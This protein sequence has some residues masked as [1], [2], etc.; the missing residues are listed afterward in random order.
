MLSKYWR[1]TEVLGQGQRWVYMQGDF[2]VKYPDGAY[3]FHGRSDEVLNV[4]GI[5][6]GTEHIEAA[7][8]RDRHLNPES[9]VGHCVVVGYPD[10]IAGEVPIAF[11]TP[12]DPQRPLTNKDFLRLF[13]LVEEV[14]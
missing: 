3:T 2:A 12:G 13:H 9:P 1:K 6:F 8:L 5:L 10:A 11:M 4:N 14:V 7:I